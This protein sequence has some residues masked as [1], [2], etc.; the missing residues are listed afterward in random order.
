MQPVNKSV[1]FY[2]PIEGDD[3][4]VRTGTI[5]EGSCIFHAML[6]AYSKEYVAMDTHG[7]MKF[8]KQLRANMADKI[9]K[10][11]WEE[12]GEGLIAKIPFQENINFILLNFYRFMS[13]DNR[14]EGKST[15]NVIKHLVGNDGDK[16][17]YFRGL[18]ELIPFEEG[19][20]QNILPTAYKKCEE[21]KI[22][23]CKKVILEET[24]KY[25]TALE[26]VRKLDKERSEYIQ[27]LLRLL[28]TTIL[29]EAENLAF[30]TYV[31]GLQNVKEEIDTYTIDLISERFD[32]DIYFLDS[33]TR[34]LYRNAS[35]NNLK[36]RK[37]VIIMWIGGIHY[38]IVGRLLSGKRIQREFDPDDPLIK[39]LY[40]FLCRPESIPE[41]YPD[42]IP[43][44]PKEY[45][46]NASPA[47]SHKSSSDDHSDT[48]SDSKSTAASDNDSG[49][50]DTES[51]T[52]N[53]GE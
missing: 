25:Y 14:A 44:L 8:V 53:D 38:E 32:R 47:V 2:S 49:E 46:P 33:K 50:S 31:K 40:S 29:D 51:D 42:L 48:D 43:Y 18:T 30:E 11:S 45:R 39:K 4:L 12:I 26:D 35:C 3:V 52:E 1:V 5:S 22:D 36:S 9:D 15:R 13:S 20:E 16:L 41:N 27:S 10:N 17:Q 34:M 24:L 37:S 6:H 28:I 7:R 21:N 19:F 23:T